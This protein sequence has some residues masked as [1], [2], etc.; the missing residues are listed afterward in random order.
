M[1][2]MAGNKMGHHVLP[3][4]AFP[5]IPDIQIGIGKIPVKLGLVEELRR[6]TGFWPAG[7]DLPGGQPGPSS[8]SRSSRGVSSQQ[9]K[10]RVRERGE[11]GSP[12]SVEA[13]SPIQEPFSAFMPPGPSSVMSSPHSDQA[14]YGDWSRSQSAGSL[15][16]LSSPLGHAPI[17]GPSMSSQLSSGYPGMHPPNFSSMYPTSGGSPSFPPPSN[18][19]STSY[20][21]PSTSF[22][23]AGSPM[24]YNPPGGIPGPPPSR[25]P[26][27]PLSP[28]HGRPASPMHSSGPPGYRGMPPQDAYFHQH[29]DGGVRWLHPSGP[30]PPQYLSKHEDSSLY[31]GDG[32]R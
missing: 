28:H 29:P 9:K 4:G 31:G 27:R 6:R 25:S 24:Y 12:E 3:A 32:R 11:S 21:Q 15:P 17:P 8:K 20:P 30:I 22:Q 13:P 10:I 26:Y 5:D 2:P 14:V 1:P 7:A 18:S 23:G 19:P 16:S